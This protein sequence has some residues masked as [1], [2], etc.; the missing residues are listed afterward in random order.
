M[1][2]MISFTLIVTLAMWFPIRQ[3]EVA[4]LYVFAGMFGFGSGSVISLAP[5]CIGGICG[6][7]EFGEWF[8][9][10]YFIVSFA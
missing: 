1:L 7:E 10:C 5:L 3:G 4:L 6:T 8:G 2:F 9:T